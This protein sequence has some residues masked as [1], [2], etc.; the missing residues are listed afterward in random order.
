MIY[1]LWKLTN[2][3]RILCYTD[4][5]E[6]TILNCLRKFKMKSHETLNTKLV[7][8]LLRFPTNVFMSHS[9]KQSNGHDHWKIALENF[10]GGDLEI[11]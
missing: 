3:T 11:D 2:A 9:D 1:D 7:D 10:F 5:R 4:W 8:I 6:L